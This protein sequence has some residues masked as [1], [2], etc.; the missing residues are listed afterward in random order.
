MVTLVVR[1]RQ[2][3]EV[4]VPFWWRR[5]RTAFRLGSRLWIRIRIEFDIRHRRRRRRRIVVS[6]VL[7]ISNY[8]EVN[9]ILRGW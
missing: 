5:R 6:L 2:D 9:V 1:I 7:W 8:F 3:L 4:N